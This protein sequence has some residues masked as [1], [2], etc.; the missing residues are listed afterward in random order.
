MQWKSSLG[1]ILMKM[2]SVDGVRY[3]YPIRHGSMRVGLYAP[4]V[5]DS[6]Q[7]HD[8][9]EIYII[10]KGS[11]LFTK[12]GVTIPF[13]EGDVFFVKAGEK[14]LFIDFS[15]DFVTWVVFWGPKGGEINPQ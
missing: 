6:Q 4:Y 11:G 3:H 14:H 2:S 10:Q 9:D 13:K 5:K 7:P 15:D 12:E 1:D 8:Q